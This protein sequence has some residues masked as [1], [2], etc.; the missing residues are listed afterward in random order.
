MLVAFERLIMQADK[1]KNEVIDLGNNLI[2]YIDKAIDQ[3]MENEGLTDVLEMPVD[4][5]QINSGKAQDRF[6][7]AF[8]LKE[9]KGEKN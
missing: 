2:S 3:N 6:D 4:L 9:L 5:Y 7:D 8:F 1:N